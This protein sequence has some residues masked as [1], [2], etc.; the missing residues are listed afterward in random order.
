MIRNSFWKDGSGCRGTSNC[1]V[2]K[3]QPIPDPPGAT[4]KNDV[5][6]I[7]GPEAGPNASTAS[8]QP[9]ADVAFFSSE[10]TGNDSILGVKGLYNV[11]GRWQHDRNGPWEFSLKVFLVEVPRSLRWGASRQSSNKPKMIKKNAKRNQ[12][13]IPV[14]KSTR[15][16]GELSL[17]TTS[18]AHLDLRRK[19]RRFKS[20]KREI[21]R[22]L[23]FVI[24]GQSFTKSLKKSMVALV[25]FRRKAG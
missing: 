15:S 20:K 7:P 19:L 3:T 23:F 9:A 21:K 4:D 24:S 12:S 10:D 13:A 17:A 5:T 18:Q 25:A 8:S 22:L 1:P 16:S 14:R 11:T 6:V 2:Q